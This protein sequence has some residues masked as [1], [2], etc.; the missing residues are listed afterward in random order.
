MSI[1]VAILWILFSVGYAYAV[2][3]L[4]N[5]NYYLGIEF[6]TAYGLIYAIITVLVMIVIF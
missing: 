5:K 1:I 6:F 4:D 2:K 3:I